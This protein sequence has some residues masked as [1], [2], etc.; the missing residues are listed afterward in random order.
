MDSRSRLQS[1]PLTPRRRWRLQAILIAAALVVSSCATAQNFLDPEGPR[2][3]GSYGRTTAEAATTFRQSPIR[4]VTF[5]VRMAEDTN[6]AIALMTRAEPLRQPDIL[7]LQEMDSAGVE[8]MAAALGLNY[9]YFPGSVYPTS[10]REFGTAVLS[11]W[12]LEDERKIVL[13]HASLTTRVRRVVTS[14]VVRRGDLR[15]RAYAVHLPPPIAITAGDRKEQVRT[16]VA[17]VA[18]HDETIVVGGDFNDRD[19]GPWFQ[20]AGFGWLTDSLPGTSRHVGHWFSLDH[21]FA[22]GLRLA[23]VAGAAGTV[24]AGSTSD[25]RAVWVLLEPNPL[26]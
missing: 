16:I 11:P 9:V 8:R 26:S 24:D 12:P 17:D 7:L 5:N 18:A 2:Y 23:R 4:V 14:A 15:I 20:A 19:V 6:G 25:H 13:P 10:H 1:T 22:R 21:V 3:V